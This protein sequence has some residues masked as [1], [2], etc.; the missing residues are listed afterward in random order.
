MPLSAEPHIERQQPPALAALFAIIA[1]EAAEMMLFDIDAGAY[2]SAM[3]YAP[4][5]Y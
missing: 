2:R 5:H 4:F 3:S 1:A